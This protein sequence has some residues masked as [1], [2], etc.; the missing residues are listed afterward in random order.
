MV[1]LGENILDFALQRKSARQGLG[2][3]Y[4]AVSDHVELTGLARADS[5]LATEA[6]FERA[7]Q[8]GR[9]GMIPSRHAVENLDRHGV[10]ASPNPR[11]NPAD[12]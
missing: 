11:R 8:T 10:K 12:A 4:D 7:G 1:Q 3:D 6:G 2:E 9:A 5:D